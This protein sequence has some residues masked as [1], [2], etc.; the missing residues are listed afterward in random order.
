M[1]WLFLFFGS[2][3][4]TTQGT[5]T[6]LCVSCLFKI[7]EKRTAFLWVFSCAIQCTYM[8]V[9]SDVCPSPICKKKRLW[10]CTLP[11][12]AKS[13]TY[14]RASVKFPFVRGGYMSIF[15][16]FWTLE[17]DVCFF[18]VFF[19][20]C[21]LF[22]F[23]FLVFLFVCLFV[24]TQVF[25]GDCTQIFNAFTPTPKGKHFHKLWLTWHHK[26]KSNNTMN[27]F[28]T[29]ILAVRMKE[30]FNGECFWLLK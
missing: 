6:Y 3:W 14:F 17:S 12:Q 30:K 19:F 22:L 26:R 13:F 27:D 10:V 25:V 24:C 20:V 9:N 28:H 18:S 21:L 15:K 16:C 8:Y 29:N 11:Q 2:V 1:K 5:R 23:F 4:E 7:E